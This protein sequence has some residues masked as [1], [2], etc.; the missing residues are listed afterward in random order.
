MM[1]NSNKNDDAQDDN[2]F[3]NSNHYEPVEMGQ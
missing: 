3:N 2:N 1:T